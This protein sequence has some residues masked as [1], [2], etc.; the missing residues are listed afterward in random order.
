MKDN[1]K[2][3]NR[4]A[5]PK[6][7]LMMLCAA[8]V[9]GVLG[10][11]TGYFGEQDAAVVIELAAD[12]FFTVIAPWAIPVTAVV[13]LGAAL[14]YYAGAKRLIAAW[15]GE[16]EDTVDAAE[17]KL[18][19]VL[20]LTTVQMALNFFFFAV[21]NRYIPI[22]NMALLV[23]VAVFLVVMAVITVLQQKVV[24]QT[25]RLNPEKQGSVYDRKFK[26]KWLAS[27]D[28]AEQR[29][30]G[31]A[32]YKAYSTVNLLCP[33]LWVLLLVGGFVFDW[34]LLPVFLVSL[35]WGVLNVTYTLEAMRLSQKHSV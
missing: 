3:D 5:L 1:I 19:W 16:D 22:G 33:I 10:F 2:K 34:G 21:G 32:A 11:L 12:S 26:E 14:W 6:F 24:D 29:Q 18:N 28:E 25:R 13:L 9:G 27:C 31:Q 15:D 8:V 23:N 35:I 30:I 4:K 20:L 7:L 17:E